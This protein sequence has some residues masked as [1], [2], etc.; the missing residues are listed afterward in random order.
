M[1]RINLPREPVPEIYKKEVLP[2]TKP[3]DVKDIPKATLYGNKNNLKKIKSFRS[4]RQ[5]YKLINQKSVFISDMQK[6][7][8]YMDISE[9]RL[10]TELIIEVSNIAHEFF[11]YGD[12]VIR[13]ES[14]FNAVKELLLPYC[15]N[16]EFLFTT[17]LNS[18]NHKIK[19]S[20]LVRRL[21]RRVKN[22]FF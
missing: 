13:E 14:K 12:K 18:V 3:D 1:S 8:D 7:L 20:T 21:Y 17:L 6:M 9:N 22:Y 2:D 5:N 4:L 16:D 15:N 19:K 11:I 10:N